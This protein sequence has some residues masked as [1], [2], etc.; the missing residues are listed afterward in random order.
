[1]CGHLST[2]YGV[3]FKQRLILLLIDAHYFLTIFKVNWLGPPQGPLGGPW[4]AVLR[5]FDAKLSLIY[6][7]SPFTM[8]DLYPTL[9][10]LKTHEG[11]IGYFY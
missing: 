6:I 2:K 7:L 3:S 8:F 4:G 10:S 5:S 11:T 1:M 9:K